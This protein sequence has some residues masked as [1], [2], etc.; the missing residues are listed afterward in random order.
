MKLGSKIMEKE[1]ELIWK[2]R[3]GIWNISRRTKVCRVLLV[4]LCQIQGLRGKFLLMI[5]QNS[6]QTLAN[7]PQLSCRGGDKKGYCWTVFP[8]LVDVA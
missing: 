2:G 4:L 5:L 3:K 1:F 6:G 7:H 8:L